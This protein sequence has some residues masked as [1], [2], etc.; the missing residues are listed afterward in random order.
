MSL[1]NHKKLASEVGDYLQ[2]LFGFGEHSCTIIGFSEPGAKEILRNIKRIRTGQD[3][4]LE[5]D[6]PGV[7][8]YT[9]DIPRLGADYLIFIDESNP[10]GMLSLPEEITHGEHQTE[11][12]ARLGRFEAY[13]E[14]FNGAFCEMLGLLGSQ[15]FFSD[16][17]KKTGKGIGVGIPYNFMATVEGKPAIHIPNLEHYLGYSISSQ[18]FNAGDVPYKD[19]FWAN[20]QS[21][22]WKV[23]NSRLRPRIRLA[24]TDADT[25][26]ELIG[27]LLP[28]LGY[29]VEAVDDIRS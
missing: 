6:S 21:A 2:N 14:A 18:L 23:V 16:F 26:L 13:P 1:D 28:G 22:G 24:K 15:A 7:C 29:E 3:Y 19:I 25:V 20:H 11:H 10:M 8:V 12:T 27:E 17:T 4:P 5:H 9:A